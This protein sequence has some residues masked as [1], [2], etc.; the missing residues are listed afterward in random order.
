M[1]GKE[2]TVSSETTK[3]WLKY[4]YETIIFKTLDNRQLEIMILER[5]ETNIVSPMIARLLHS[6]VEHSMLLELRRWSW[7]P[8]EI[9]VTRVDKTQ[10]QRESCTQKTLRT[11]RRCLSSIQLSMD[12]CM[13]M[14]TLSMAGKEQP[15]RTSAQCSHRTRNT[16]SSHEAEW[17]SHD[18][19]GIR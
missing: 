10:N 8:R 13:Q 14:R 2:Y 15:K 4:T 12:H 11:Y 7:E 19:W 3:N 5:L 18:S 17:K 16:A 6:L 1:T 9:K